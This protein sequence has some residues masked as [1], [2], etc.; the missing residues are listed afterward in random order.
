M[1]MINKK[2]MAVTAFALA[3][4]VAPLAHAEGVGAYIDDATITTKAK[5]AIM[6]DSLLKASDVSVTTNQG[7][8]NLTGTVQSKDQET[9][10]IR[11][12]NKV[13]GVK[14]VNSTLT[15]KGAMGTMGTQSE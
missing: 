10:A 7:V 3:I 6:T 2:M 13:D 5:A 12:V 9:Q 1:R 8:V 14:S 15:V 4:G 11:D